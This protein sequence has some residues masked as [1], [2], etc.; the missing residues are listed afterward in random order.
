MK[1]AKNAP[2]GTASS[3]PLPSKPQPQ[4]HP[5]SSKPAPTP[6]YEEHLPV[7]KDLHK[8]LIGTGGSVVRELQTSTGARISIP[9]A[10]DPSSS[11][12]ISGTPDQVAL[13]KQKILKIVEEQV[14]I[15]EARE[16]K[17]KSIVTHE[18][19]EQQAKSNDVR[20]EREMRSIDMHA[21][22]RAQYFKEA[23]EAYK[24]GD[25][26]K[27]KILREKAKAETEKMEKAQFEAAHAIF[28]QINSRHGID[29]IDL[30]GQQ[31]RPALQLLQERLDI[32]SRSHPGVSKLDVITGAGNHSTE[33]HAKIKPAVEQFL[34][35]KNLSYTHAK[36]GLLTVQLK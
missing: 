17:K 24:A 10:S 11:I 26:E 15:K 36:N 35:E 13:A 3:K 34:K 1:A 4:T 29:V 18:E 19:A 27:A 31:V 21:N 2:S 6:A 30:H 32:I 16:Q 22:Q 7:E 25:R 14:Q 12:T 20:Y 33:G 28:D 23:E 8:Y 9:Q 5:H